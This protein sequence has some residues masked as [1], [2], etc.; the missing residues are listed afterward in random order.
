MF[1]MTSSRPFV[2]VVDTSALMAQVQYGAP[3]VELATTPLLLDEMQKH[4]LEEI[5]ETLVGTR[6]MRILP[7]TEASLKAVAK[8]AKEL[9]D[10]KYLSEPDQQL[11]ALALDLSRQGYHAV[12]LTDDYSIQ[13]VAQRLTLE[14]RSVAQTGIRDVIEW[15]T[16]CSACQ[17]RFSRGAKGD[18][19]P[20]CGTPLRRRARRKH[21]I[22]QGG[23]EQ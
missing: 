1:A 18:I 5:V 6:K 10:L 9:G 15:E 13:N 23:V 4:G 21:P 8:A 2:L 11:L 3:D 7:P 19:C 17:R 22:S 12:V 14:A 20:V 16:Y